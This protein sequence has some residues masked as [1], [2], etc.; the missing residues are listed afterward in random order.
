MARYVVTEQPQGPA[1]GHG[2]IRRTFIG[3]LFRCVL[4]DHA[5]LGTLCALEVGGEAAAAAQARRGGQ[6][7][8]GQ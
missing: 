1:Q 2:L 6:R 7:G 3:V 5:A 4:V 8:V